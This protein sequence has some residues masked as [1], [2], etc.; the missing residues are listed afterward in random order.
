MDELVSSNIELKNKIDN[1]SSLIIKTQKETIT[2]AEKQFIDEI[3]TLKEEVANSKKFTMFCLIAIVIS[4][5]L[6]II[7]FIR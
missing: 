6:Y 1:A 4:I 3:K 5:I 7:A 2:N